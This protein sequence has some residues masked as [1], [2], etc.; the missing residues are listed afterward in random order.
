[1]LGAAVAGRMGVPGQRVAHEHGVGCLRVEL[2]PRLVGHPHLGQAPAPL[3]REGPG[4][5]DGHELAVTGR[6]AGLPGAGHGQP[7]REAPPGAC[8]PGRG[9][10]RLDVG[11]CAHPSL[12][13]IRSPDAPAPGASLGGPDTSEASDVG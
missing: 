12:L 11:T 3:Q 6:V 1:M 9:G 5:G 13:V 2:T 10:R 4:V 8:S 7:G